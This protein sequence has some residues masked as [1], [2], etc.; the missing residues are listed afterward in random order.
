M[1]S[2]APA[3]ARLRSVYGRVVFSKDI[4]S[5]VNK[6]IK[7]DIGCFLG[8]HNL[9]IGEIKN[10][11]AHPGG[12]KVMEAYIEA[13]DIDPELLNNAKAILREYGNMSSATVLYELDKF[14]ETGFEEGYGLMIS[15]GP[16][17]SSEMALLQLTVNS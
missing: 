5:I 6:N 16:G 10:F 13:L 15:L 4:P 17:F 9:N 2:N 1:R 14:I 7:D 8:K 3:S 11:I 12:V